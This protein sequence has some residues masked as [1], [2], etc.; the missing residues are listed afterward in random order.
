LPD[1]ADPGERARDLALVEACSAGEPGALDHLYATHVGNVERTIGRLV[2]AT[3]DL[4]D[5]VQ[6][7]FVEAL[8]TLRA[9]RGIASLRTWFARIAVHVVARHLRAHK[10]RRHVALEAVPDEALPAPETD[11]DHHLDEHRIGPRLHAL[12]DRIAPKKRI[13]LVLFAVEGLPAAEVAT[14]MGATETAT[15]SRVFFARRELR[16]LIAQDPA[17]S[18]HVRDLLSPGE[19]DA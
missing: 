13:A 10:V 5:L 1:R 17:L 15:R 19:G 2:G 14:L 9:Y 4:E 16:A 8:R 18:A 6:Q 7:T 11:P 3:P 12:L